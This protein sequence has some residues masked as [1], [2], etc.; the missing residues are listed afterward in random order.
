MEVTATVEVV[1]PELA[2]D[3]LA[4]PSRNR[5]MHE[6]TVHRYASAMQRGDWS[7]TGEGIKFDPRGRLVDGQ[8]RLAAVVEGGESIRSLVVRGVEATAFDDMDSGRKRQMADVLRMHGYSSS[9]ALAAAVL[10][11]ITY[12]WYGD[13]VT[14]RP[15]RVFPT[16]KQ[17]LDI[18]GQ[19]PAI[20]ESVRRAGRSG[21]RTLVA[22]RAVP[23]A[24]HYIVASVD[25]DDAE[26]FFT[27][28]ESGE[29]LQ[30]GHPVYALRKRLIDNAS[31]RTKLSANDIAALIA[32]AWN[33]YRS[34][35]EIVQLKWSPGGANP[36]PFPVIH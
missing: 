19:H 1:T 10:L 16:R 14:S 23:A 11:I 9:H 21:I 6:D 2:A 22:S 24:L 27:L 26:A 7:L 15:G 13:F 4:R 18:L 12:D 32:K 35:R 30:R 28:L 25:A 36:E 33:A 34:G 31:S 29:N 5:P 3:W 8:H 20:E 17:Q